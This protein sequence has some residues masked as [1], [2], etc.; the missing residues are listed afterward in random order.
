LITTFGGMLTRQH[1]ACPQPIGIAVRA[2]QCIT[3]R[4]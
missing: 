1:V 2:G 4:V 3:L